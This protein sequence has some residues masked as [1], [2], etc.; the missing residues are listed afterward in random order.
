MLNPSTLQEAPP[1]LKPTPRNNKSFKL[2]SFQQLK[3]KTLKGISKN[4]EPWPPRQPFVIQMISGNKTTNFNDKVKNNTQFIERTSNSSKSSKNKKAYLPIVW[5]YI[6]TPHKQYKTKQRNSWKKAT[7]TR[8]PTLLLCK[9]GQL[10]RKQVK[11][12]QWNKTM[13]IKNRYTS[14]LNP[15]KERVRLIFSK[16]AY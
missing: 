6:Y 7:K 1:I 10:Q 8:I 14:I 16:D 3:S 13:S 15:T 12:K 4:L 5:C 11:N 9:Q 2:L